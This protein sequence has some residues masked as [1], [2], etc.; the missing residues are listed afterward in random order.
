MGNA[1]SIFNLMR[2]INGSIGI[3]LMT[4]FLARRSQ[5]HQNHLVAHVTAGNPQT[6]RML[7]GMRANFI[8]HGADGVTASR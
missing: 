4:T 8:E 5:V 2:D 6:L 3:A 1:T 7:Q